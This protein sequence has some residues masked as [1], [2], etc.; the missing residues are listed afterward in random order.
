[1]DSTPNIHIVAMP[2]SK[3]SCHLHQGFHSF[4][5]FYWIVSIHIPDPG[6][7]NAVLPL[8]LPVR[9]EESSHLCLDMDGILP[10][11]SHGWVG[12]MEAVGLDMDQ[13]NI[14]ANTLEKSVG[15]VTRTHYKVIP[16]NSLAI[17]THHVLDNI[18]ACNYLYF[19]SIMNCTPLA[20]SSP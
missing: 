4:S 18:I 17:I 9:S 15:A 14:Q 5:S 7:S 12:D 13:G 6:H 20:T 19:L 1:M 10:F 8:H 3:L 16:R 2:I 11:G